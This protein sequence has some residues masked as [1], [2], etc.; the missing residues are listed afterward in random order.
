M[1]A[2]PPAMRIVLI[3]DNLGDA[4]LMREMF[5]ES[6]NFA[7]Q[8]TQQG[9][10]AKA[11]RYLAG[12]PVDV[13]LLDL[14]LPEAGGIEAVRMARAAAPNVPLVVMTG[15][16]DDALAAQALHAGAHSV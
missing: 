3:E 1:T 13:I 8:L 6:L 10:M 16:D 14:G 15:R 4:R 7:Y 9:S 11:L 5:R 12:N 2:E